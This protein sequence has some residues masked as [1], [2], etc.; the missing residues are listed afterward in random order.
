[1]AGP[2]NWRL[3]DELSAGLDTMAGPSSV[4]TAVASLWKSLCKLKPINAA[5]GSGR[6]KLKVLTFAICVV[7]VRLNIIVIA[8][9][10]AMPPNVKHLSIVLA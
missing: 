3:Y 4:A 7:L 2:K 5:F 8:P 1:M 6:L 10:G 9:G